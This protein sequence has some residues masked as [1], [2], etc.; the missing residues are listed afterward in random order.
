MHAKIKICFTKVKKC[1]E[2]GIILKLQDAITPRIIPTP[3]NPLRKVTC[4]FRSCRSLRSLVLGHT[5]TL[6]AATVALAQLIAPCTRH[7]VAKSQELVVC[8]AQCHIT[9]PFNMCVGHPSNSPPCPHACSPLLSH[10]LLGR[11]DDVS[12]PL[13]PLRFPPRHTQP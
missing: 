10:L 4:A 13:P 7:G 8:R 5:V 9:K 1:P 3:D 12:T 2:L 6:P 11:R